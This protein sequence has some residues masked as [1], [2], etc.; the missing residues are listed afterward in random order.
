MRK[1]LLIATAAAAVLAAPGFAGAQEHEKGGQSHSQGGAQ[2][3]HSQGAP[4]QH[5]QGNAPM[6]HSQQPMQ[7]H[8]QA[9]GREPSQHMG[10][11][12]QRNKSD[13]LDTERRGA[14]QNERNRGT[15]NRNAQERNNVQQREQRNSAQERNQREQRNTVQERNQSQ[16]KNRGT[17][18]TQQGR[19][20]GAA[21]LSTEQRTRIRSAV[22]SQR[23]APRVSR[24]DINV[25]LRAGV[26]IPRDRI[27]FS[28]VP[29]P[30]S[31]V[32]IEPEW[33]GY[34]Y[35]L[36]GDEVVVVEPDTYEIVAVLPA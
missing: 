12:E 22:I 32:E 3:Q 29:L 36:V 30:E 16:E 21:S 24:S 14:A 10:Q 31:I 34:L 11:T 25:D 19:T 15:E 23:N 8:T 13:R 6:Q 27:H 4:T 7:Q 26:R 5:S 20:H 18:E 1:Q 9:P 17:A 2:M 35:F 33:R 28:L